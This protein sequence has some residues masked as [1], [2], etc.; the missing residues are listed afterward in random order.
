MPRPG[1]LRQAKSLSGFSVQK[2]LTSL[3]FG[4]GFRLER[5]SITLHLSPLNS[6]K[7]KTFNNY[8]KSI[9]LVCYCII[10]RK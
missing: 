9:Y 6:N 1:L 3:E 5:G 2:G 4:H 10:Q 7:K 8:N